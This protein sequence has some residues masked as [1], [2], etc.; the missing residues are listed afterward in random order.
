MIQCANECL[1]QAV[2]RRICHS[3]QWL[4]VDAMVRPTLRRSIHS[5][6]AGDEGDIQSKYSSTTE[7][8][9]DREGGWP[10]RASMSEQNGLRSLHH[11]Q[12]FDATTAHG[13]RR[14]DRW[15]FHSLH[16]RQFWDD[17]W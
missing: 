4:A 13:F 6:G 12:D 9:A 14:A 3:L 7:K 1:P 10:A 2:G 8:E 16:R 5:A 17:I 11:D 15:T